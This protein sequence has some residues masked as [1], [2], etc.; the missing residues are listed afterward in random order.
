MKF[1]Y[2]GHIKHFC[3]KFIRITFC[4]RYLQHGA[5]R[6]IFFKNLQAFAV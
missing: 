4:A 1:P 3:H 5:K 6:F 2:S